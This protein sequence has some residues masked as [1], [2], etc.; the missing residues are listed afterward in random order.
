LALSFIA[1]GAKEKIAATETMSLR[2]DHNRQSLDGSKMTEH[3]V[4]ET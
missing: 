2:C 1:V 4:Q 3:S